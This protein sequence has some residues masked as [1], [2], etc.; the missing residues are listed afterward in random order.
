MNAFALTAILAFGFNAGAWTLDAVKDA[1]EVYDQAQDRFNTG[2]VTRT[3]VEQA[4]R[5]LLDMQVR[6]KVIDQA[7]YCPAALEAQKMILAGVKEE[8]RVGQRSTADVVASLRE[9]WRLRAECK[10]L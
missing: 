6:A 10:A 9:L 2:E 7:T 3:D 8:S 1:Q 4:H 5:F